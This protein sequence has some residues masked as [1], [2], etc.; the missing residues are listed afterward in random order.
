MKQLMLLEQRYPYAEIDKYAIMPNHVHVI[1]RLRD[2]VMPRPGLTAIVGAYKSL[3]T[4]E[5]NMARNTP[6][7]KQ[8]QRSFYETV[9][10]SE[11]A[12]QSCWLYIDGNPEKWG[13]QEEHDWD[14][15]V[16]DEKGP[17]KLQQC[18]DR[19]AAVGASPHPTESGREK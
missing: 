5:I 17:G 14:F 16:M 7:Q 10:R 3:A 4:R 12:Y 2:G 18:N 1:I 11:T 6:G 8:F 15:C 13:K 19:K 9:I